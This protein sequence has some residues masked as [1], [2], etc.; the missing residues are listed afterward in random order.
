M[1]KVTTVGA[2]AL[3]VGILC[4]TPLSV[5]FSPEG[6]L[7]LSMDRA[8]AV[9]GRLLTPMSVAGVNRR[10]HR[11][12]YRHGITGTAPTTAVIATGMEHTGHTAT[13]DTRINRTTATTSNPTMGTATGSGGSSD[14]AVCITQE[15]L[16]GRS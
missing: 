6:N 9:I 4:A 15:A 3:F 1:S 10:A 2:T 5:R 11:R 14:R 13:V 12:A 7:S 8:S 16:M